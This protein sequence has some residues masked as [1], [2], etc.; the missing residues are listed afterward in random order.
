MHFQYELD[1]AELVRLAE[2]DGPVEGLWRYRNFLPLR[3][4]SNI[5]TAGEGNAAIE[6]WPFLEQYAA[7][8][9]VECR[10]FAHRHDRSPATGTFKDLAGSLVASVLKEHGVGQYAIA[11]TGNLGVSLARY[12]ASAE[13]QLYA[14]LPATSPE[15][16]DAEIGGF[17]QKVFRVEGDY[18]EAKQLAS[19][20]AERHGCFMSTGG[21]D[22][23][24]IEAKKIIYFEWVRRLGHPPSVYVQALSGGIGPLGI[25]KGHLDLSRGE[26]RYPLPRML[27]VQSDQCAPMADAWASAKRA[28]FPP[29]W[30]SHYSVKTR[31][32]TRI[33]TLATGNPSLY[34]EVGR[35]VHDSGGEIVDFPEA[36]AI[37]IAKVVAMEIGA[38]IGPASAVAVG[39]FLKGV[40]AGYVR[41]GDTVLIAIGDG[42]CRTPDFALGMAWP[43]TAQ[44][45]EDCLP[46]SFSDYRDRL[47]DQLSGLNLI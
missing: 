2:G 14:F 32:I 19:E 47:R 29:G 31:P 35:L 3:A 13:I 28:R 27:L 18:A 44:T 22:P 12:L 39:G 21:F 9:G 15:I 17:G 40:Q 11:T 38:R 34:P 33:S 4:S 41:S 43:D 30:A 46:R 25:E 5:V 20:F 8:Y 37:L 24:R 45:I 42:M 36:Q 1:Y 26:A 16:N 10:V 7:N 6:R 23:I